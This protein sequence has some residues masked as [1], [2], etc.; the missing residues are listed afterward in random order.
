MV[1]VFLTVCGIGGADHCVDGWVRDKIERIPELTLVNTPEQADYVFFSWTWRP[2]YQPDHELLARILRANKPVVV[3]DYLECGSDTEIVLT[4]PTEGKWS[5]ALQ[6]Y[7]PC[8]TLE[9]LIRLYFKREYA[10]AKLPKTPYPIAP[11]DFMSD[12]IE[13]FDENQASKTEFDQRPVDI[14]FNYGYSGAE[15]MLLHAELMKRYIDGS[16][17][18]LTLQQIDGALRLGV[19]N[20]IALIFTP[21]HLRYPI[22]DILRYQSMSKL[23]LSLR[24][25]SWKCFRHAEACSNAV[26]ALQECPSTFAFPWEDRQNCIKL[27]N[28]PRVNPGPRHWLDLDESL[29]QISLALSTDLYPIY[30][31]GRL[32]AT[33]YRTNNYIKRHWLPKLQQHAA[34]PS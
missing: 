28:L 29:K 9:P 7:A 21:A 14:F 20:L 25:A 5:P 26:M 12:F 13:E 33:N 3:F 8:A 30:T 2:E 19:K 23:S 11:T 27:P 1:N 31:A 18:C 16:R 4:N 6:K 15:R 24:G 32:N 17:I 34:W 10:P 22:T